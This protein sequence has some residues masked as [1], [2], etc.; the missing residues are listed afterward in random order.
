M[1]SDLSEAAKTKLRLASAILF[2]SLIVIFIAFLAG[3]I[4]TG[5]RNKEDEK[6]GYF[7]N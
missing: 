6:F 4:V 3:E 7:D 1:D 2:G 5:R